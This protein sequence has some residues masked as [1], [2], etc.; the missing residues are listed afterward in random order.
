METTRYFSEQVVRKRPYLRAEWITAI[1]TQPLARIDQEDGR[2]RF[3]GKV[4]T[5]DG[6]ET[7]A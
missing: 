1:I 6:K 7:G 2:I 4:E 5:D 3:W